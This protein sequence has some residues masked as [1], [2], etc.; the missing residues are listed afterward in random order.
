MSAAG[1]ASNRSPLERRHDAGQV[2]EV[3]ASSCSSPDSSRQLRK[4]GPGRL[5][6]TPYSARPCVS[7]RWPNRQRGLPLMR[8][9]EAWTILPATK[10][11]QRAATGSPDSTLS[12]VAKP[13]TSAISPPT[14]AAPASLGRTACARAPSASV[15]TSPERPLLHLQAA[16]PSPGDRPSPAQLG[17]SGDRGVERVRHDG[18]QD[19]MRVALDQSG[20]IG[21]VGRLVGG[22]NAKDV[23]LRLQGTA[24]LYRPI[25]RGAGDDEDLE[26]RDRR[27]LP[28]GRPPA[29][30]SGSS[31]APAR[32]VGLCYTGQLMRP[33]ATSA[34]AVARPSGWLP[35]SAKRMNRSSPSQSSICRSL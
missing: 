34:H 17:E 5:E 20:L 12:C 11:G 13:N 2:M 27:A 3:Q 24:K 28:P 6:E 4:A 33:S 21:D 19:R 31:A 23:A 9:E 16:G 25:G 35:R 10:L 32:R 14:P 8:Q 15:S 1:Q 29:V 30:P 7:H 22:V 26:S 18:Q